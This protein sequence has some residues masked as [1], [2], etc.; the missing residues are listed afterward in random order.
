MESLAT[1]ASDIYEPKMPITKGRGEV[2]V[3]VLGYRDLPET[4][5]PESIP[6][7]RRSKDPEWRAKVP[8]EELKAAKKWREREEGR[9]M[10]DSSATAWDYA[11][12]EEAGP[13]L[14]DAGKRMPLRVFLTHLAE[15]RREASA[16]EVEAEKDRKAADAWVEAL[17]GRKPKV[18][19][20]AKIYE[21]GRPAI[22][23]RVT[24]ELLRRRYH[25]ARRDLS[26]EKVREALVRAAERLD[27][28]RWDREKLLLHPRLAKRRHMGRLRAMVHH[29][30]KGGGTLV[31]MKEMDPAKVPEGPYV[32]VR[33]ERRDPLKRAKARA[34]NRG[35]QVLVRG[36]WELVR[37]RLVEFVKSRGDMSEDL[38]TE[39]ELFK[40]H[41]SSDEN[42]EGVPDLL[43]RAGG[44][45][46]LKVTMR[47]LQNEVKEHAKDQRVLAEQL[48]ECY[49]S[50]VTSSHPTI[51]AKDITFEVEAQED[52]KPRR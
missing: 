34:T 30:L 10:Q 23:N 1:V 5:G 37:D 22:I 32:R 46:A 31:T 28:P 18:A 50:D 3:A 8:V 44:V 47:K 24:T 38:P 15:T 26:P 25:R 4:S 41:L 29:T 48:F 36:A 21:M 39:Y 43:G 45:D 49:A 42:Y 27:L 52:K 13:G 19:D 20:W 40:K 11:P 33:T 14:S 17:Q 12:G 35:N 7:W 16:E 9:L 51:R 6:P 2:G